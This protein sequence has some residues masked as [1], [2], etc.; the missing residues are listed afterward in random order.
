MVLDK[1]EAD[2]ALSGSPLSTPKIYIRAVGDL[3]ESLSSVESLSVDQIKGHLASFG[4]FW[5]IASLKAGFMGV[6]GLSDG[7]FGWWGGFASG[8]PEGFRE[9]LFSIGVLRT[10]KPVVHYSWATGLFVP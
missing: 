8:F 1:L 4:Q 5:F 6:A 7:S 2:L 9:R 10:N 3:M